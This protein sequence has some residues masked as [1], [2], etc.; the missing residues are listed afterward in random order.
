MNCDW[1]ITEHHP[2]GRTRV[3]CRRCTRAMWTRSAPERT[4]RECAVV[5]L[6]RRPGDPLPVTVVPRRRFASVGR[7]VRRV[8]L[9]WQA[10]RR[11]ARAGFPRVDRAERLMRRAI[12][13]GCVHERGLLLRRCGACGCFLGLKQR[14]PTEH[15]PKGKWEVAGKLPPADEKQQ[16]S[17][18]NCNNQVAGKLPVTEGRQKFPTEP[19]PL[20]KPAENS[21]EPPAVGCGNCGQA[22]PSP[23]PLA[24]PLPVVSPNSGIYPG[25]RPAKG[26]R[27]SLL[28]HYNYG[29][30]DA[31]Q[32]T[33]ILLHLRHYYPE[34]EVDMLAPNGHYTLYHGLCRRSIN[35]HREQVDRS[36]YTLVRDLVMLEPD[37]TFASHPSTKA[38]RM[39]KRLFQLEPVESLCRYEI[40]PGTEDYTAAAECLERLGAVGNRFVLIHYQGYSHKRW[41]D[42]DE[43]TV[44]DVCDTILAADQVPVLLD[45]DGESKIDDPRVL[46]IN[47]HDPLWADTGVDA[48]RLFAL[49]QLASLRIGIDSGP[50]H[51]WAAAVD[52]RQSA[53]ERA[54]VDRSRCSLVSGNSTTP[55]LLVVWPT[56][57]LH[58]L[59]YFGLAEHVTHVVG[60]DHA[61]GIAD[62]G[63][64]RAAGAEYFA[65]AYRHHA[66]QRGLRQELPAV[67]A[68]LLATDDSLPAHPASYLTANIPLLSHAE[69]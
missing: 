57:Y 51:V 68:E 45:L 38:E 62:S 16:D 6:S 20:E 11:W 30:G 18:E 64:G 47:K 31:V 32:I 25:P 40:N 8:R 58:P 60:A 33:T 35:L 9:F 22:E 61:R 5:D 56:T 66:C 42:I 49:G 53:A 28:L 19:A 2:D 52:G 26:D 17:R 54:D 39:L 1:T 46:R 21:N 50:G 34:W 3:T 23:P 13:A 10:V 55:P 41:K 59:H 36:Q 7:A 4:Y 24:A 43:R 67:V 37:E 14:W 12:C 48:A 15:C 65:R 27:P 44:A 69:N 63:A 29:L